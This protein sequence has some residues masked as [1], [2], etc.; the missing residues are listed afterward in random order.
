MNATI[1]TLRS[2]GT[3]PPRFTC[4][5]LGMCQHPSLDCNEG[6]CHRALLDDGHVD[7]PL[8]ATLPAMG[9]GNFWLDPTEDPHGVT[10]G[11]QQPHL[12]DVTPRPPST[13]EIVWFWSWV[14]MSYLFCVG[15]GGWLW[16]KYGDVAVRAFWR[17]LASLG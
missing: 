5:Q 1:H 7:V 6:V 16:G 14:F 3:V 13:G 17:V 10:P 4:D 2:S 12:M 11:A 9:G 15:L 8:P